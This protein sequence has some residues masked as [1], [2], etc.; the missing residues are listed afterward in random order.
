MNKRESLIETVIRF[1]RGVEELAERPYKAIGGVLILVLFEVV[2]MNRDVWFSIP[3]MPTNITEIWQCVISA[4]LIMCVIVLMLAW[5]R[6]IG[7]RSSQS[8]EGKLM[9]VFS[10]E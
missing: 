5:I 6:Q 3:F 7:Y 1:Y 10:V 2:W 9:V 8:D 4:L